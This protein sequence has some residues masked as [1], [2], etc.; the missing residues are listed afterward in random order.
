MKVYICSFANLYLLPSLKRFYKEALDMNIFS[1]IFLYEEL[2]LGKDFKVRF[3][4]KLNCNVR[5]FGYWCWKPYIV[6]ES[7]KRIEY[8]DILIYA[9]SGCRLKKEYSDK[10]KIYIEYAEKYD[11]VAFELGFPDRLWTKADLFDYF[12][13]LD[14]KEITESNARFATYFIIKKTDKTIKFINEWLN[15][16]Y[17]NFN[18]ADDSPSKIKNLE[19]F[20]ENRHDQSVFSILSKLYNAKAIADYEDGKE[21]INIARDR[22]GMYN[23]I[24]SK[25]WFIPFKNLRWKLKNILFVFFHKK[26]YKKLERLS[27]K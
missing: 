2:A 4:D 23:D 17:T 6:L 14:N 8:E 7:L 19:G 24:V 25:T 27:N 22:R 18:L 15:V 10:M 21:P 5:G 16:F 11:I 26:F 13:V 20:I 3:E 12:K 9:D 1:D